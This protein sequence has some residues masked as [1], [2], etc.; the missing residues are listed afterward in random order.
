[1]VKDNSKFSKAKIEA[2]CFGDKNRKMAL[3][4]IL[5]KTDF[6][7]KSIY[8]QISRLGFYTFKAILVFNKL[9]LTFV[10]ALIFYYFDLKYHICIKIE[11][12]NSVIGIVFDQ[13]T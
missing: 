6:Y 8:L 10:K 5:I 11:V 4:K 7:S 2:K 1:M 9:K 3:S 13:L 12:F